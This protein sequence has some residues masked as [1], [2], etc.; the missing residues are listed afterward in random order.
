MKVS[1]TQMKPQD[2]VLLLKLI[3]IND[4]SW[5][6]QI[7]AGALEM[8]QSEVSES[9]ARSKYSGLLDPKGKKGNE[10]GLY[11]IFTVWFLI[12]ISAKAGTGGSWYSYFSFSFCR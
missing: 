11:G 4:A 9:V 10:N 8:S 5:K 6:Q 3:S 1:N 7:V 2:I 12:C